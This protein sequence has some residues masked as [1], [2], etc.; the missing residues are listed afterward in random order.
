MEIHSENKQGAAP[1]LRLVG[2]SPVVT[3]DGRIPIV[4]HVYPGNRPD[5]TQFSDVLDELL[6]RWCGLG[7]ELDDLTVTYDAGQNSYVNHTHVETTGVGFV[8]SLPPSQHP[9]L[10]AIAHSDYTIVDEQRFEGLTAYDT[11][12]D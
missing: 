7:G 3:T 6:A 5:V 2:L 9:D 11:T 10:L 4:S 8:T 1:D 12:T